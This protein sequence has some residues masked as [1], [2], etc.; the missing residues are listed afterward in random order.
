MS[1]E[2]A[3]TVTPESG[4]K[5]ING[6]SMLFARLITTGS[7]AKGFMQIR[8]YRS[9]RRRELRT[10]ALH[11]ALLAHGIGPGDEVITSS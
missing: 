1:Y 4:Y 3:A 9:R 6:L 8:R 10:A 7:C 11:L 2:S 5:E